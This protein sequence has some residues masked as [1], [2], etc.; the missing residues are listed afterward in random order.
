MVYPLSRSMNA[1]LHEGL[2]DGKYKK[3]VRDRGGVVG[4]AT[5]RARSDLFDVWYGI[6]ETPTKR[7]GDDVA[8]PTPDYVPT[9]PAFPPVV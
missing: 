3:V 4:S 5:Y 1:D 9:P 7:A 8:G 6:H 2:T